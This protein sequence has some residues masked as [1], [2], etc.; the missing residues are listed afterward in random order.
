[1]AILFIPLFLIFAIMSYAATGPTTQ[2]H[3]TGSRGIEVFA[4]DVSRVVFMVGPLLLFLIGRGILEI[5]ERHWD[6]DKQYLEQ[7]VRESWATGRE[8]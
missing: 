2:V 3:R 5:S 7:F 8:G 6:A 4:N 1:V